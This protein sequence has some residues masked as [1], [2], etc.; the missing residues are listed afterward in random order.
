V[1]QVFA[2]HLLFR[3]HLYYESLR[4]VFLVILEP[5]DA[6]RAAVPCAFAKLAGGWPPTGPGARG[7]GGSGYATT[8]VS[9]RSVC[10][11]LKLTFHDFDE[12]VSCH[13]QF[14]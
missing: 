8:V 7:G 2:P 6:L 1:L 9:I 11:M 13:P 10:L 4:F 3:L 12:F 5:V 14:A